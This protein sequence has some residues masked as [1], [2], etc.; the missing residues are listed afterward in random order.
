MYTEYNV[1]KKCH[2]DVD[3]IPLPSFN[4]NHFRI[5]WYSFLNRL[6]FFDGFTCNTCGPVPKLIVM[7]G[8][9]VSFRKD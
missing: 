8:T 6:E 2:A 9:A 7:D 5:S 4:Y 3:D 1:L